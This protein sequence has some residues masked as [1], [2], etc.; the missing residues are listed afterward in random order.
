MS[1]RSKRAPVADVNTEEEPDVSTFIR[2]EDDVNG[3]QT[4]E[5]DMN[6]CLSQTQVAALSLALNQSS[7]E[8]DLDLQQQRADLKAKKE[9]QLS[10]SEPGVSSQVRRDAPIY[11]HRR[12][13]LQDHRQPSLQHRRDA[14]RNRGRRARRAS[15]SNPPPLRS[16]GAPL[17]SDNSDVLQAENDWQIRENQKL[18]QGG[19]GSAPLQSKRG[20]RSHGPSPQ[21]TLS[22][23]STDSFDI[24]QVVRDRQHMGD[25]AGPPKRRGR[26]PNKQ[27]LE[28]EDPA[29]EP[30]YDASF[31]TSPSS[32]NDFDVVQVVE[33]DKIAKLS[34]VDDF[35]AVQA[36]EEDKIAKLRSK[37]SGH[38]QG[39]ENNLANL[40]HKAQHKSPARIKSNVAGYWSDGGDTSSQGNSHPQYDITDVE[41]GEVPLPAPVL[42]RNH[43]RRQT[44][45]PGAVAVTPNFP[46]NDGL[47]A[48]VELDN[49][50]VEEEDGF[51]DEIPGIPNPREDF[52]VQATLV[53]SQLGLTASQRLS[54]EEDA[55][56][57]MMDE[58]VVDIAGEAVPMDPEA[59]RR[60]LRRRVALVVLIALVL[61]GIVI[62]SVLGTRE[63]P[64]EV[65]IVITPEPTISG[66]PSISPSGAPTSSVQPSH[67]PTDQ[68]SSM[69]SSSPSKAPD[70]RYCEDAEQ[71]FVGKPILTDTYPETKLPTDYPTP[72]FPLFTD[73]P[74]PD[75]PFTT[76]DLTA[77]TRDGN[78]FSRQGAPTDPASPGSGV[79]ANGT[80]DGSNNKNTS[81]ATDATTDDYWSSYGSNPN[82]MPAEYD[83]SATGETYGDYYDSSNYDGQQDVVVETVV[84]CHTGYAY[85]T[86][87]ARWYRM[88]GIGPVTVT[89]CT[90]YTSIDAD[91]Q[92]YTSTNGCPRGECASGLDYGSIRGGFSG[93]G[94]CTTVSWMSRPD[95]EYLILVAKDTYEGS[96]GG[97]GFGWG[98]DDGFYGGYYPP[99]SLSVELFNNDFC[100]YAYK[101]LADPWPKQSYIGFLT[102]AT[103]DA[104]V[105]PAFLTSNATTCG[106]ASAP[107]EAGVW[108]TIN[109]ID[110]LIT[111]DTCTGTLIDTQITVYQGDCTNLECVAGNDNACGRF[112]SA[113]SWNAESGVK[114]YILVHGGA[115]VSSGSFELTI[116][117]QATVQ[118]QAVR[119][120]KCGNAEPLAL[121][122]NQTSL[123]VHVPLSSATVDPEVGDCMQY[124]DRNYDY[125]RGMWYSFVGAPGYSYDFFVYEGEGA[126]VAVSGESCEGIRFECFTHDQFDE[127]L[128]TEEGKTYLV[129]VFYTLNSQS[130]DAQLEIS[131]NKL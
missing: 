110:G 85:S 87:F 42:Q 25:A 30:T 101:P 89:T 22:Q 12:A 7:D 104:N 67:R 97:Y 14:A 16:Y 45:Q 117:S 41:E 52:L 46:T 80:L 38:W 122:Y 3:Y 76:D 27:P 93:T 127:S 4:S 62:G 111:A 121:D 82:E 116:Q 95:T 47:Q 99:V 79:T 94:S 72:D 131:I 50:G 70:N 37:L 2:D 74:T 92:V 51:N 96:G 68:P 109:G 83:Y 61:I 115:G 58:M 23:N 60:T 18:A 114:Y 36:V 123:M 8:G 98:G 108:Y 31:F 35:D 63:S 15:N 40:Q 1:S 124:F 112:Q 106:T 69:P 24:L 17:T 65:V 53:E 71:L 73:Y 29:G 125:G 21:M 103:P 20:G 28:G 78:I 9:A 55:R 81:N 126:K 77:G 10:T 19:G 102:D 113:V 13:S 39:G 86:D 130:L 119:N 91:I 5:D 33:Q 59:N 75:F 44:A 129:Y 118:N 120:N 105:T 57:Q 64:D 100:D 32:M 107:E 56:R 128:I 54:L 84:T 26:K 90:G 11:R 34:S 43:R 66:M 6:G 48:E 88:R 49:N